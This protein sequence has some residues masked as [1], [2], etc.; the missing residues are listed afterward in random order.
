M[1][2][3]AQ[4]RRAQAVMAG[5]FPVAIALV[6]ASASASP[7]QADTQHH[8]S[9]NKILTDTHPAWATADKDKGAI[10]A[11]QQISTR[12]YL[13]GQDPAGLAAAARAA[14]DPKSPDYQHY[15]TPAQIQARFGATP[16]QVAAVQKWL[17]DSGL[18][19]SG[20]QTDWIDAVGDSAAVQ[21]AFGTEIKDYQGTD[22]SVKYAASSSAVIPA[23]VADYVQSVSGL[24]Q[25]AVRVHADSAKANAANAA[26]QNCSPYWGA[27][28]STAW[29][30]GVNP[31]PTP[32]LPCSYTPQQL[33]DAYGVTKSGMTGKGATIAVVDWF[34]ST[35]MLGD[36]NKFA[37]AHGDKAFAPGQYSEIVDSS[38]WTN[39]DACGGTAN[40]AGEESL[41]IEMTHGLAPDANIVYVG[42][43]SCTDAD[44][45][46]AEENIVDKHLADV[47]SN[48]WGEIMHTTD[49]QDLDPAEIPAYDRIFQK[50][51]LE[52]IGFNF[53]SGD[54]GDDDPANAAGGGANCA[55]DSARKQTEWPTSDAWVTSVGGTTLATDSQGGYAWEAAMGDHV[56]VAKQGDAAWQAPQGATVPFSFYFGGGGGTSED[57]AQPF[58]QAGIVPSS[59]ANGGHDNTRAMRTVPDVAM[60]G[61]LATSVLVGMSTNGT[62]GEG[63]YGGTSVAAP[64][65]SALQAD[66]KQ[67][68]GHAVG[69]A[70][71]SLYALNGST[72]FHDVTAHPAGLP[73]VLEG[74]HVSSADPTRGTMYHAGQDTSLAA[75]TGYDDAT[76]LGSPA[77]DYLAKIST[78]TPLQ[79]PVTPP[80]ANAPVVA[81]IAGGDRYGT[82]IAV[83]KTSFPKNGS[84]SAVVLATGESFPDAL[85]GA[86]LA[87][88]KGGPLLLTPSKT[89]DPDVVAEIHR[90]LAPG[91]K[92]YVL[93]GVNA[94]SDKVVAGLG[95][96]AGQITRIAGTDRFG[97]SLAIANQLNN[98][99]GNVVL[100]TG[101][102][103][104]DALTAA[105]F[106]AVYGAGTGG[107][108]AILLTD[109]RKLPAAVAGFVAG[110]HSV[111]AVGGQ[112]VTAA[113][114]LPNRDVHAQFAGTDR[115]ATAAMVSTQFS[116]PH[117]V[118]VATGM[119]FADALTGATMLAAAHSPLLLTYSGTLPDSTANALHGFSQALSNGTV[120][121]FGGQ[122]AVSNAV[123]QQVAKAVGGRVE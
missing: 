89:V 43:N 101:D 37:T 28:T 55:A 24:S 3:A 47:V 97:T 121:L 2:N 70:N 20:V 36:A 90:V 80:P 71:P 29:P 74:I 15:L 5:V 76:G 22:G 86:P 98:P 18:K 62:Y 59:L 88:Q 108:A 99:H 95:L 85:S 104:A 69:F 65:F 56:G 106:S 23:A 32:L 103:F 73:Q 10:P 113:A 27:N 58:Y 84:A 54:C 111:A 17:T 7:A 13:T 118:G 21:R 14:S 9:T 16:A 50:G 4:R 119:Q 122:A 105:P 78:V 12:V 48:S 114:S 26:N 79:P 117:T 34:G 61:A 110:A 57:I 72:A 42:A 41:D 115:F 82:A 38:Q 116:N 64:E 51:A 52:G 63:G 25:A 123:E 102:N 49:G 75:A 45:M 39:V 30:A 35:T 93:G 81:R 66:A 67:A 77:D 96:P 68:A 19:I 107:P 53:S 60:N 83:S 92:V 109:D 100:A 31:G 120:E 33:R 94:V 46:A 40:V 91:G 11:A 112:A 44:L 8:N 87:A 6:A 1:P